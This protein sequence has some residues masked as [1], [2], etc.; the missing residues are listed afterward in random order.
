[1]ACFF[2]AVFHEEADILSLKIQYDAPFTIIDR[3]VLMSEDLDV[4]DK[5]VYSILCSYASSTDRSCFPSYQTIA[6]KAV[7]SRRKVIAVIAKLERMGLVEKQEQFNSIGDNTSNLYIVKPMAGA[8]NAPPSDAQQ[9]PPGACHSPPNACGTPKLYPYNDIQSND[10]QSSITEEDG[11]E[12]LKARINYSWFEEEMPGKLAFVD[13]LLGY[14][15]EL[16]GAAKPEVTRLLSSVDELVV[17]EFL[18]E[19]KGRS[20]VSVK[21]FGGYIK[22]MFIEFLRRREI[23]LAAI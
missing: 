14:I 16:E 18:D 6:N 11:L 15:F 7:C 17:L 12:K 23:E 10:N 4:Y 8:G 1:M 5:T 22:K 13:S 3:A 19:I 2:H 9:L 21:N 20:F